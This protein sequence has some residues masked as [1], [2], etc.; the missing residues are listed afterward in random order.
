MSHHKHTDRKEK[1]PHYKHSGNRNHKSPHGPKVKSET[2]QGV[3][4]TNRNGMGFVRHPEKK[5]LFARIQPEQMMNA[6]NKDVVIVKTTGEVF[7]DDLVGKVIEI[8]ERGKKTLVGELDTTVS[9]DFAYVIPDDAKYHKDI[10]I[11]DYLDVPHGNKVFVEIESY[12]EGKSPIGKILKDLGAKGSN[13]AEMIAA[14]Y[15]NGFMPHHS[16]E[17]EAEAA[18]IKEQAEADF[19]QEVPKRRDMRGI[20]TITI[21][22]ADAKDFDDALSIET[23][24][25]GNYSI[26]VH[27]ADVSHYIDRGSPMDTEAFER[28][29]SVYLVDRTIPMLPE[30]LSN[31]LCSLKPKEDRLAF[32]AIFEMDKDANVLNEWF[33][34]TVIYS[35]HRYAYE[36]AQEV[37]DGTQE[38]PLREEI[39]IFLDLAAKL[40]ARNQAHGAISFESD[41]FKFRL[42]EKGV[43]LEIYKKERL[44]IHK[45]IEEFMLLANRHV[46]AFIAKWDQEQ[47][48]KEQGAMYRVHADPDTEKL[49]EL[50]TFLKIMGYELNLR[51]DGS[52]SPKEL[53]RIIDQAHG[54]PEEALINTTAIR[55]MQK[56]EYSIYNEGHFG[57]AFDNYTHFTS[58]IRRYPD[59]TVHRILFA[60]LEEQP[61][62]D[63]DVTYFKKVAEQSSAQEIAAT[64]AERTS[65]KYKQTEFMTNHVGETFTGVISG[66]TEWGFYVVLDDTGAEGMIKAETLPGEFFLYDEK[67]YQYRGEKT[68]KIYRLGDPVTVTVT[69]ANLE[70]REID[71]QVV[72]GHVEDAVKKESE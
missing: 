61:L 65:I 4:R 58:P 66:I 2:F 55:T 40:E 3:I 28:S 53:N 36:D 63:G 59:L 26:G 62:N 47:T 11:Y 70:A 41:E 29:F 6:F 32:S 51:D 43:P 57:L 64:D 54:E 31:D 25:N 46:A 49:A 18:R 33:G 37:A 34:K 48:M 68:G 50:Q 38:G 13:E 44:P 15:E 60:I 7:R 16:P 9:G 67:L 19:E 12:P 27:I 24:P 30:I 20:P 35:D 71:M 17:I 72:E 56:A 21:D 1:K 10:K 39:R 69:A 22:P 45:M 52:I 5:D 14:V 42:D 23:L 8:K